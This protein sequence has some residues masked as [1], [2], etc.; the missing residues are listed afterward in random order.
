M[1]FCAKTGNGH[2]MP[3][4]D[5]GYSLSGGRKPLR[6]AL[7]MPDLVAMRFNRKRRLAPTF[8]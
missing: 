5:N 6:D 1:R 8:F 3:L 2:Q 4:A 7:D